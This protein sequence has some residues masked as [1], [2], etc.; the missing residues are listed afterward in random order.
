[1]AEAKRLLDQVREK[2]RLRHMSIRTEQTYLHWIKRYIRF[3]RLKHP[4]EMGP[5]EVEAFLSN[6]AIRRN[7]SASTQNVALNS[8]VF[9][10]REVLAQPFAELQAVRAKAPQ[11]IP[12]VLTVD[13]VSRILRELPDP[14]WLICCLQYGSGLR[15][16]ESVRLRV[17]DIDFQHRSII[18]RDGKGA[19]DRVVTLPDQIVDQLRLHIRQ[20]QSVYQRDCLAGV[21]SVYL[22]NALSRKYPNAAGEWGWQYIFAARGLSIDPRSGVRQRHHFD[23]SAVQRAVR[24]AVRKAGL[25]KPASCH[26]FRHS[27]ATHFLERGADIRTVQ[28]QLGHSDVKTTQIYTHVLKRGGLAVRSPLDTAGVISPRTTQAGMPGDGEN[29]NDPRP[30]DRRTF[31]D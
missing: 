24:N 19:K 14:H 30:G 15:L 9:L 17:K 1:M 21:A 3:H 7:V 16:M 27:F 29:R 28:E 10:Y 6:L 2:I 22:P 12:T 13:E 20:R 8:L 18:V 26:T 25:S 23:E 31:D 5:A 11:R 4:A